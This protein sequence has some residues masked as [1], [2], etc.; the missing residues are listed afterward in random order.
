MNMKSP[1]SMKASME[2]RH[3]I[4]EYETETGRNGYAEK[5]KSLRTAVSSIQV[6]IFPNEDG[7]NYEKN[8]DDHK[9]I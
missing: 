4:Y 7:G 3:I 9:T 5:F 2:K 6:L 8:R 1:D